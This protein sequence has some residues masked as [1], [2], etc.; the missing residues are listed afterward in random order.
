[1][2]ITQFLNAIFLRLRIIIGSMRDACAYVPLLLRKPAIA[3]HVLKSAH[4]AQI[5]LV[6][7][8]II[9][10]FF[11]PSLVHGGLKAITPS[12]KPFLGIIHMPN[13]KVE[14]ATRMTM[15][16][17]WLGSSG[18]VILLLWL[19]IPLGV[20]GAA[21][22]SKR[23]EA[24]AD[25]CVEHDLKKGLNL[26]SRALAL[27]PER[28][29]ERELRE[30]IKDVNANSQMRRQSSESNISAP[31]LDRTLA[32]PTVVAPRPKKHIACLGPQSRYRVDKELGH[33]GMG[34]VYQ[35]FDTMLDRIVAIKGLPETLSQDE[36]FV[37]RFHMEAKALAFLCHPCIVQVYDFVE[38]HERFWIV[39][40]FVEGGDLSAWIHRSGQLSMREAI[41]TAQFLA[42]AL[43]YAH[44]QGIVHRDVKPSN[45]L[46][47]PQLTPKMSD[48]G[49]AK[50]LGSGSLTQSGTILGSP[51]YMSPEQ[52]S[53][54]P[55][56]E[57][58]DVYA[59]GITL[60]EM[61]T[62]HT[63]FEGDT[64]SLLA[65]HITQT[66]APPS[67]LRSD[68]PPELDHLILGMLIKDPGER[69]H[70]LT[71]LSQKLALL[72]SNLEVKS[73]VT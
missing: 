50:L 48:F 49:L 68:L 3:G 39:L 53:G 62:G 25:S 19:H 64:G 32:G 46:L 42:D 35:A 43:A 1:M 7:L 38:D 23:Y 22:R 16:T 15:R 67:D 55:A 21:R 5:T 61:L 40:E 6:V 34:V 51:R 72:A 54:H 33:G 63:P 36:K 12:K 31:E 29:H 71:D 24:D 60:Y 10:L 45:V 20:A 17:L 69:T 30:K 44:E 13:S 27:T 57:R 66:P 9:L 14:R 18:S 28:E 47:T 41:I 8:G 58:S 56:D 26:Y 37:S 4:R 59:L 2:N 65:Q 70:D 11:A 52:A 73:K